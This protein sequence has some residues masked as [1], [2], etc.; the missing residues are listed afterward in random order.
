MNYSS[1]QPHKMRS[2]S[3]KK[4]HHKHNPL[5][6]YRR[7]IYL[8]LSVAII[9]I[10]IALV[11]LPIHDES[12][13]SSELLASLASQNATSL[14]GITITRETIRSLDEQLQSHPSTAVILKH[15]N[16]FPS[17]LI[18]LAA[19]KPETIDF[20]A[21]YLEHQNDP[22][23]ASLSE[24]DLSD[25]IPL[26]LQWDERWGYSKYGNDF[27]AVNG[28]GPTCLS[29]I[30]V[31]LTGDTSL[32]PP[33][34]SAFSYQNGY[35][36]ADQGTSWALMTDGAAALGLESE[37]IPADPDTIRSLLSDEVPIIASMGP[38]LFTTQGHFIVLRGIREDGKICIN[39]PNSKIRSNQV[40][41]LSTILK[42]CRN[43][44]RF[45]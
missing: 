15:L 42:E 7:L 21:H 44:W 33:V 34:V 22:Q 40:W 32:T 18:E 24:A 30:L 38:G 2:L 28:C 6:K 43:L 39:D 3:T 9:P 12:Q 35:L 17:S 5:Y 41:E 4:K 11:R 45:E 19:M 13:S 37:A 14:E 25:D 10:S 26:F 23:P 20:V 1:D 29:M 16:K 36:T 27:L 8:G 31:G